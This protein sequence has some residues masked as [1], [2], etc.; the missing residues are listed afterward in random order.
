MQV[1]LDVIV[2]KKSLYDAVAAPRYHQQATP[3][4][5]VYERD[6]APQKTIDGLNGMGHPLDP[7]DPIGDVQAIM[8]DGNRIIAVA[9]P[10][11]GGAAG[12]F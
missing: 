3:D 11:N 5:I 12:G 8:F 6:R 7:R 4:A 2:F 1:V 9:D 10:R